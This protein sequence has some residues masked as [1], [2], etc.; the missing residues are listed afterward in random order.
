MSQAYSLALHYILP[1]FI[2]LSLTF[3][4][5]ASHHS[6]STQLCPSSRLDYI[7]SA[8]F[9]LLNCLQMKKCTIWNGKEFFLTYCNCWSCC[10]F[11]SFFFFFI[12]IYITSQVWGFIIVSFQLVITRLT[13]TWTFFFKNC[14]YVK[15]D[16]EPLN[17]SLGE[18][19]L[20]KV[21]VSLISELSISLP[22]SLSRQRRRSVEVFNCPSV[23][24]R[25]SHTQ[26]W[27]IFQ[28]PPWFPVILYVF[29]H[30]SLVYLLFYCYIL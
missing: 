4:P 29:K 15:Y 18:R 14:N 23:N 12:Y 2:S 26:S 3:G 11:D 27:L 7:N 13:K 9:A 17:L 20:L 16:L 24:N 28:V 5:P 10:H 1:E 6:H 25:L 22:L 8:L 19:A 21:W 30:S